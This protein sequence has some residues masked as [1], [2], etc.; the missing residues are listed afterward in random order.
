M[1]CIEA[2]DRIGGRILT[3]HDPLSI[4]PIEL[5]AEFVHGRAPE[6]LQIARSASL[7]VYDCTDSALHIKNGVVQSHGDAWEPVGQLMHQMRRV[8][9][10]GREESFAQFLASSRAPET[11]KELSASYVEGFN[12]ARKEI[13]GIAS[14]AKDAEAADKIHGDRSFRLFSGYDAIPFSVFRS[15]EHAE[16]KLRLNTVLSSVQW[17]PGSAVLTTRS[18]LTGELRMLSARRI[19]IAVPLGVLQADGEGAGGIRWDPGLPRVT[20]AAKALA[21]GNVMRVVL[22]F[23]EAFWEENETFADAGFLLSDERLFPTWWTPLAVRA[24]MLTGW[25]AGPHADGLIGKSRPEIIQQATRSLAKILGTAPERVGS[26]VE[27]AYFH[28]WHADPFARGAY[29]YVPAGAMAAREELAKPIADTLYFAGE[30]TELN[31]HSATVHGAIASGLRA[32]RQI[33]GLEG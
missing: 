18:A 30:A 13:I 12:A 21:F 5:G 14:L 9:G 6:I 11:A 7:G 19:L 4:L 2:R 33:V 3:V 15:V 10:Q 32:T 26:Q 16:S 8:A 20:E 25:S 23:R 17:R 31:G 28:D 22:R 27:Q 1:L 29:S 24:P